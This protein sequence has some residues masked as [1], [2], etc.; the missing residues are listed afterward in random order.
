MNDHAVALPKPPLG[1]L[2]SEV[3][4]DHIKATKTLLIAGCHEHMKVCDARKK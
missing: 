4:H 2:E 1:L 3:T